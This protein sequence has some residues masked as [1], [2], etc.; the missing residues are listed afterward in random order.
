M[1]EDVL[2][3]LTHSRVIQI[4]AEGD[5]YPVAA[6]TVY[7]FNQ[8]GLFAMSS[9]GSVET[10]IA[11]TMNLTAQ[12]CLLVISNSGESAALLKQIR[13]AKENGM[14]KLLL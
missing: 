9:G 8:I 5:T 3:L 7:K 1:F 2:N 4:S 11:Q 13:G 14:K 12:D 10:A 6:D